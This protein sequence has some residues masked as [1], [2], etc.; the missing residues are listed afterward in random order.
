MSDLKRNEEKTSN[1]NG[2]I[3]VGIMAAGF[4]AAMMVNHEWPVFIAVGIMLIFQ[5]ANGEGLE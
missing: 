1:R 4:T 2:Y 3:R 5:M